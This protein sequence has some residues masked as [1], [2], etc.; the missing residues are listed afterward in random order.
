MLVIGGTG[1]EFE[2]VKAYAEEQL[3]DKVR[4]L[5]WV[6]DKSHLHAACDAFVLLSD[7]EGFGMVYME[8]ASYGAPSIGCLGGGISDAIVDGETGYLVPVE[9]PVK[10]AAGRLREMLTNADTCR[11]L[12]ENAKARYQSEFTIDEMT[13]RYL[14]LCEE[15]L[16]GSR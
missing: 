11:R 1:P 7:L 8:A 12:G 6:E 3:G 16:K 14:N 9:A 10:Q 13:N 15:H 5:G 4:L 2:S